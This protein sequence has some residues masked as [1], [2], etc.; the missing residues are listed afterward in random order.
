LAREGIGLFLLSRERHYG[1]GFPDRLTVT[2]NERLVG[3]MRMQDVTKNDV[4]G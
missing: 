4:L 2:K 3:T 1:R